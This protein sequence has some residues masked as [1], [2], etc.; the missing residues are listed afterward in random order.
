MKELDRALF[1]S[2]GAS[3]IGKA[4]AELYI[5]KGYSVALFDINPGKK[6]ILE[7]RS[8]CDDKAQKI[9][10][11]KVDIKKSSEVTK[12][13]N[14]AVNEIGIPSRAINCAGI[15]RAFVFEELNE[16]D[17]RSV[18]E[19]NL[20]GSRNFAAAVLPHMNEGAKLAFISSLAGI[21]TNYTYGAY[22][23]S[24]FGVVGLAG[25]LRIE[26]KLRGI[27]VSVICPPE[28]ITPMV[29]KELVTMHHVTRK[30][31]DFAGTIPLEKACL[32][33]F[34]DL[35]RGKFMII[36][37]FKAKL[38]YLLNKLLPVFIKNSITDRIVQRALKEMRQREQ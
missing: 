8:L 5:K 11:Y 14:R 38:T 19:T 17:Y 27:D 2:G 6:E 18:V 20:F 22:S 34:H 15:Q 7:L 36:P 24:K 31:K 32:S 9:A 21:V 33:I 12:A 30:L 26:L 35:E 10:G 13:V 23:S 3:G 37:G 25:V 4:L 1:V 29:E 28:I 16:K